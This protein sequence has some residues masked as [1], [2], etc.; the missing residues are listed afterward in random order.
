MAGILVIY[1][2][3]LAQLMIITGSL[4]TAALIGVLPFAAADFVKALVAGAVSGPRRDA[5]S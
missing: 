1:A 3:G 4:A 5:R 2:G